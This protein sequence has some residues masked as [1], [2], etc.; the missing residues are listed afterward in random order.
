MMKKLF[1]ALVIVCLSAAACCADDTADLA[2]TGTVEEVKAAIAAGTF[3]VNPQKGTSPLVYAIT[4]DNAPVVEFLLSAG[5]DVNYGNSE[6]LLEA[7]SSSTD[8]KLVNKLLAAGAK[9][10]ARNKD[11]RTALHQVVRY[12]C[13]TEVIDAL[14]A[15]GADI[16]AKDKYGTTPLML[17]LENENEE[18]FAAARHLAAKGAD[19]NALDKYGGNLLDHARDHE[20]VAWLLA[21]GVNP[22]VDNSGV[23]AV[24]NCI[25]DAESVK[26][27]LDAGVD[28]NAAT[29]KGETALM[30]AAGHRSL[31][32]AK[33]L[34]ERGANVN[35]ASK[36][37]WTPLIYAAR[38]S[39]A[40][41]LKLFIAAGANVNAKDAAGWTALTHAAAIGT[42]WYFEPLLKAG[43]TVQAAFEGAKERQSGSS[44]ASY[45]R[46]A[47]EKM[48]AE[49]KK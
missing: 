37:G 36:K 4:W 6:A 45:M 2:R 31:N 33:L 18:A 49:L 20:R 12:K 19:L 40:D 23:T 21:Q 1:A 44:V 15:A 11:E 38:T 47:V 13:S 10:D 9:V 35:A 48:A 27:L 43:A 14:L 3:V 7:A 8:A 16:N 17:A 34:L 22:V 46:E 42:N 25:D 41:M 24:M 5:A 26:L 28:A 29:E 30:F 39:S 32:A